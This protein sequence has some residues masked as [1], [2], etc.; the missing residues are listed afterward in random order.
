MR[1]ICVIRSDKARPGELGC[2]CGVGTAA[3]ARYWRIP[4]IVAITRA[5]AAGPAAQIRNAIDLARMRAAI[6]IFNE[7]TSPD[8][9]GFVTEQELQYITAADFPTVAEL[10]DATTTVA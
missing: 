2:V 5:R 10:E 1:S 4:M 3:C 7:K 8:S 6:R 9:D